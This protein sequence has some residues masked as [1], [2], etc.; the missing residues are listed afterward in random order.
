MQ[1]RR[2]PA[3]VILLVG[4]EQRYHIE[5]MG[6]NDDAYLR[7]LR[8]HAHE[9]RVFLSNP[10]KPERERS[11]VRAFL[12]CLGVSFAD[13]EIIAGM[14]EPVDVQFR[15][16]C[17]QIREILGSRE[18][19]KDWA[20]RAEQ[21]AAAKTV[22]DVMTSYVP[23]SPI[24][25]AEAAGMAAEAL[26]EKARRYGPRTCA[27]LDAL[28]YVDLKNSHLSVAEP[29]ELSDVTAELGRQGW[30]SVSLLAIPYG[31]VLCAHAGA[32][33]FLCSAVGQPMDA[34]PGP[35]GWFE[36]E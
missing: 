25:L 6:Q 33:Q 28:V 20:D 8:E 21:Y 17:F 16:A 15:A 32:P 24:P 1:P 10:L 18:R 22:S 4:H 14:E 9:S 2:E 13:E 23:S 30:R 3:T 27:G 11:V 31:V 26:T 5:P 7:G 35:D 34:W 36:A 19:G 29:G 12:R